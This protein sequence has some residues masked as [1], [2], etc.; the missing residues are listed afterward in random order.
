LISILKSPELTKPKDWSVK[1]PLFDFD[2]SFDQRR[3]AA[4]NNDKKLHKSPPTGPTKDLKYGF[5]I[6]C[7]I[8]F[9]LMT[10]FLSYS[11]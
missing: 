8:I 9:S 6:F 5:I 3:T 1:I 10:I 2:N 11:K 7:F 4:Y